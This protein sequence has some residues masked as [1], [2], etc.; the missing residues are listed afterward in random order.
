[1]TAHGDER[2]I[3]LSVRRVDGSLHGCARDR[4]G[5]SR[6]F[7]GMLGLL[8]ALEALL[9]DPATATTSEDT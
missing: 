5:Q 7:T 1:M 8:G 3:E 6:E 2:L 4:A 9:D